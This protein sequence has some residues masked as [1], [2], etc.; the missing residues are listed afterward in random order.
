MRVAQKEDLYLFQVI[1][2]P[3]ILSSL[4]TMGIIQVKVT[5]DSILSQWQLLNR[6]VG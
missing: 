4:C 6:W 3:T 1:N 2:I 5:I